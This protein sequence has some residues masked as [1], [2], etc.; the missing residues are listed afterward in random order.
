M[1]EEDVVL[2]H[3]ILIVAEIRKAG[4]DE[5]I[6]RFQRVLSRDGPAEGFEVAEVGGKALLHHRHH[7]LRDGIG[8]EALALRGIDMLGQ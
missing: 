3:R 7:L 4:R 1:I 5:V 6:E 8:R 2:L